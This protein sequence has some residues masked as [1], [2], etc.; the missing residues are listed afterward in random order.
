MKSKKREAFRKPA[1]AA[2]P[3]GKTRWPLWTALAAAL[4]AVWWAYSPALDG[5]FLFDDTGQQFALPNPSASFYDWIR[6]NR[7]VTM[8]TYWFN[9]RLSGDNPFSYHVLSLLVHL[10]TGGLVFLIARRLL[11]WS[12]VAAPRRELLAGFVAGVYLLHPVQTEAVAYLAGRFE[13]VSVMFAFAAFTVFL[14]RPTPAIRWSTAAVVLAFFGLGVLSKEHIV[15]LPAWLILTDL[16]WNSEKLKGLRNNWRLYLP[17]A[18]GAALGAAMVLRVLAQSQSAGFG[19]KDLRWYEYLFTQFRALFVYLGMFLAPV[20][21]TADWDFPISHSVLD[22]GAVFGLAA[23]VAICAAAWFY[24]RRFPLAAYGWF[25]FLLL[26]APTSSVFP[27]RDPIAERRLYFS[28]IGLLLI[29]ADFLARLKARE[30]TLAAAMAA[31]LAI[32][33][34]G[35]HARAEK[36]GD[37]VKLWED[38]AAKSPNKKRV[39]LQLAQAYYDAGLYEKALGEFE[40]ASTLEPVDYNMLM[41]WGLAYHRL[42][43]FDRALAKFDEAAAIEKTAHVYSQIGMIY[44]QLGRRADALA[45]LAAA[46]KLDPA[47]AA[48]YNYRAK[49]H[50]QANELREAIADYRRA[51]A[52]QPAFADAREELARAELM[53]LRSTGGK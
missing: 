26:M 48:T 53:L 5:P 34:A 31:V 19:M 47:F 30:K 24:R 33:G 42:N 9:M 32:A 45:A 38:T 3:G 4:V 44:A 22:R 35:T 23:L 16:W 18:A 2:Q 36:W 40:R 25:L 15:A 1:A 13:A 41:N 39:R 29:A 49:I 8:L 51:L 46:E 12:G 27:I 11:E 14:Y 50:F 43:R 20:R 10:L 21:L 17:M 7:P 28:M 52:L 6:G 37:A